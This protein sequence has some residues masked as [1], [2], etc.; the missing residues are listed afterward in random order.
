RHLEESAHSW[1]RFAEEYGQQ[2]DLSQPEQV[3]ACLTWLSQLPPDE[4]DLGLVLLMRHSAQDQKLYG[5]LINRL[6]AGKYGLGQRAGR[7]GSAWNALGLAQKTLAEGRYQL[8][9]HFALSAY[10]E[11]DRS[12]LLYDLLLRSL[13]Q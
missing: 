5:R 2:F 6:F 9:L 13:S 1:P 8:A 7:E 11:G 12:P 10:Q 4:G 3:E